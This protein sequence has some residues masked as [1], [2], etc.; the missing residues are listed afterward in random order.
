MQ[1]KLRPA[2]R[3]AIVALRTAL[4]D[5]H[6]V[7]IGATALNAH[8]DLDRPTYD[9]DLALV[10]HPAGFADL[11]SPLGWSRD[12]R[13]WQRWVHRDGA[14]A[15]ILP[16]TPELIAEGSVEFADVRMSLVGFDLALQHT[17]SCQVGSAV[18]IEVAALAPLAVLKIVAWLDRPEREKDLCD[19]VAIL[20]QALPEND[21]RRWEDHRSARAGSRTRTR[22]PSSSAMRSL[23]SAA[24]STARKPAHS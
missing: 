24:R 19:L 20:E 6:L 13:M 14:L 4:P 5:T 1:L 2:Q 3:E 10:A 22:A 11:L 21:L 18:T 8:V 15:D 9:V 17:L 12:A 7:L 16:A 23:P